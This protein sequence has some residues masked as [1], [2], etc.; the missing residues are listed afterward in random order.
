MFLSSQWLDAPRYSIKEMYLNNITQEEN[1]QWPRYV[2]NRLSVP[3]HRFILWLATLDKLKTRTRLPRMGIAD[4]CVCP[5]CGV[6]PETVDHLF[7]G[8]SECGFEVMR[9]LGFSHCKTGLSALLK[10]LQRTASS[11]FRRT[12][13]YHCN[14]YGV[15]SVES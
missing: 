13:A 5:I 8:C 2:C 11:E 6:S 12:V 10:C 3:K 1:V 9:W 14:S 7:F 15:P 4:D